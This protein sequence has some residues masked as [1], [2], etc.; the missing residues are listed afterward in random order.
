MGS[1]LSKGLKSAVDTGLRVLVVEDERFIRRLV[2]R[3]LRQI[4]FQEVLEAD[5]GQAGY[6]EML[7]SHPD[8]I[9]CD[10]HME[11]MD[12]IEFLRRVRENS[13]AGISNLPVIFLTG[14]LKK[15][16]VLIAKEYRVDGYIS[17]PVSLNMLQDRIAAALQR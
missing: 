13:D 4:G 5:D 3:M 14:D 10:V 17:K 15:D 7:R 1:E 12:G 6:A 9:I 16:T 8:I 2:V 11:P